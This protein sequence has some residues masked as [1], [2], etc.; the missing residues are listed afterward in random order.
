[1]NDAI[2]CSDSGNALGAAVRGIGIT[3]RPINLAAG[4]RV[5]GRVYHVQNVNAYG[6]R[7]KEWMQRF[8]GITT[9][10]LGGRRLIDR[11][12]GSLSPRAILF[13]TLGMNGVQQLTVT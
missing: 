2:L 13:A 1:V 7:L 4:I 5:V 9:N 11:A 10:Y 6:S 12:H 8:H 3:H